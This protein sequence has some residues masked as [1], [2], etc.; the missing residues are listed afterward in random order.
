METSTGNLIWILWINKK[1]FL[2]PESNEAADV[3]KASET[4]CALKWVLPAS[5]GVFCLIR[6]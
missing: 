1:K 4:V 6:L 5:G 3:S 2:L